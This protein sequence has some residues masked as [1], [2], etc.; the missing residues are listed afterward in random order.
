MYIYVCL[1][2]YVHICIHTYTH[3]YNSARGVP[4]SATALNSARATHSRATALNTWVCSMLESFVYASAQY[5]MYVL[6]S[7]T[8]THS[9]GGAHGS[10]TA[11]E[12]CCKFLHR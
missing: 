5:L 1:H 8:H 7:Y 12:A 9:A 2:V 6:T 3:A 11:L 10:A 4:I